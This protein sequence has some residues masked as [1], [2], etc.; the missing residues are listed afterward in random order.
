[1]LGFGAG[2]V[3]MRNDTL[4]ATVMWWEH[5][6]ITTLGMVIVDS[7]FRGHGLGSSLVKEALNHIGDKPV[8]LCATR[9]ARRLYTRFGFD[10]TGRIS[11]HQGVFGSSDFPYCAHEI[12]PLE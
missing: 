8:A 2:L 12:R 11:Q 6:R 5:P 10:E 4:A 7:P 3:A 9:M 1:M